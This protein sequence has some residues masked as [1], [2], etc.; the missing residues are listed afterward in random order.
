MC[1]CGH[2]YIYINIYNADLLHAYYKYINLI[3]NLCN[4]C[5]NIYEFIYIYIYFKMMLT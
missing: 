2:V 4:L 1:A 5:L 3:H